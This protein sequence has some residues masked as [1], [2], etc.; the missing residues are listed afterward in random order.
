MN[1]QGKGKI[2]W[3]DYTWSPVVGC[4]HNCWYCYAKKMNDRFKWIDKWTEPV[5][6]PERLKKPYKLKSPSKIFVCSM[7]DLFGRWVSNDW[8]NKI[9]KVVKE[10]PQHTF[11]FLTK[12]SRRY[13]DFKFPKNCWLGLTIDKVKNDTN[14][15]VNIMKVAGFHNYTFISFEPLLGNM[16]QLF[17][18][19][20]G[21]SMKQIDFVIIGGLSGPQPFYPPRKWINNIVK[22]CED[23]NITIFFKHNLYA[24]TKRSN[25]KQ[26]M[27]RT[28]K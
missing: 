24:P 7:A 4:K 16:A 6:Y 3:T 18:G 23:N 19:G 26:I 5:F 8:I 9:L 10:N 14:T 25:K 20:V 2:E 1:K 13:L 17:R 15:K 11:Q 28:T 27:E 12:N 21:E 22:K